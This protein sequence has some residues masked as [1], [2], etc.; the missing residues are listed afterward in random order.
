MHFNGSSS[1]ALYLKTH[2]IPES[3]FRKILVENT[4]IIANEI[5]KLRLQIQEAQHIKTQKPKINRINFENCENVLKCLLR[6]LKNIPYF[7][8]YSI[9]VDSVLL[10]K[11]ICNSYS[12]PTLRLHIFVML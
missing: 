12:Y 4:T 2:S 8:M 5:D 10:F 7:L 11:F 9:S 6:F 3:K 1:T